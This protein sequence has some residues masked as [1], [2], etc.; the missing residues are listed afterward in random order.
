VARNGVEFENVTKIKQKDNP[1][2][3]FL[4]GG[5]Y[6]NYYSYKLNIERELRKQDLGLF[7]I[8][9]IQI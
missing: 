1:K 8:T 2:F 5:E 9:K 4:Y 6:S 3:K 7:E